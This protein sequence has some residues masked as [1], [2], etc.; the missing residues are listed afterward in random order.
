MLRANFGLN[1]G[2]V[3]STDSPFGIWTSPFK[4]SGIV[5][6]RVGMFLSFICFF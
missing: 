5:Q 2:M 6:I 4:V 1:L 3:C